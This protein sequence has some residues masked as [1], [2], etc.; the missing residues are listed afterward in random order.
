MA[1]KVGTL[2][3]EADRL[4]SSLCS[5]FCRHESLNKE[6]CLSALPFPALKREVVTVTKEPLQFTGMVALEPQCGLGTNPVLDEMS[7]AGVHGQ[8]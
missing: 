3:W 4:I 6:S 7:Q 8:D 1:A 5:D 2:V